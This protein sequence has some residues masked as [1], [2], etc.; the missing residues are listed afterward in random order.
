MTHKI[1]TAGTAAVAPAVHWLPIDQH[2]PQGVKLQLISRPY[3]I[4]MYGQYS[5]RATYPFH[6][7]WAPI[8]TFAQD[9]DAGVDFEYLVK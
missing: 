8:P 6:T 9:D 3:G 1:N 2:T 4:A 7:H 5:P